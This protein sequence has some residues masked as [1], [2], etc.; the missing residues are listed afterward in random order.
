MFAGN[1]T[2][3]FDDFFENAIRDSLHLGDIVWRM[4][5]QKRPQVQVTV[6]RMRKERTRHAVRFKN[7]LHLHQEFRQAV[8]WNR[9]VFDKWKRSRGPLETIQSRNHSPTKFPN[10]IAF[11]VIDDDSCM[12]RRGGSTNQTLNE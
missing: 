5:I 4:R 9:D 12:L 2:S 1:H 8:W 3:V 10:E 6:S 7:I 11:G